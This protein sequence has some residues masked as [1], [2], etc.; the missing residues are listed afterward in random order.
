MPTILPETTR[1]LVYNTR[2]PSPRTRPSRTSLVAF[3]LIVTPIVYVLSYAPVFRLT[4]DAVTG[5]FSMA[6]P[7][8][9]GWQEL[10][11]PVEWLTDS[12]PMREPLLHGARLW[13][14]YVGEDF[15][16]RSDCRIRGE[17]PYAIRE[18]FGDGGGFF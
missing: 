8:R 13:G 16:Y 1:F 5:D 15:R 9:E 12:T 17:D 3:F 14:D 7:P 4:I 10:Y 6:D 2:M 11:R 18:P